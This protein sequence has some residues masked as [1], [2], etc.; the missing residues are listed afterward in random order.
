MRVF[1]VDVV[2][3]HTLNGRSKFT[4]GL[5]L[6]GVGSWYLQSNGVQGSIKVP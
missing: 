3:P 6:R 5:Q 1:W 2:L 4:I